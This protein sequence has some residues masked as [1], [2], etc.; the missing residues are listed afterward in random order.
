VDRIGRTRSRRLGAV[1][2]GSVLLIALAGCSV[3]TSSITA[4]Q[5]IGVVE[6]TAGTP[7][8]L[9]LPG[10]GARYLRFHVT[11]SD[12]TQPLE[13][14]VF[15]P[16]FAE[17]DGASFGTVWDGTKSTGPKQIPLTNA[18]YIPLILDSPNAPVPQTIHADWV[19]TALDANGKDVGLT[20]TTG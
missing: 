12:A 17:W 15:R 10:P 2:A 20:C 7:G 6:C 1:L 16:P 11:K 18:P 14:Y 9:W 13:A 8:V 3:G 19:F 5:Q 4:G